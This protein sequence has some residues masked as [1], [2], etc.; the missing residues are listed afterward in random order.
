MLSTADYSVE[1]RRRCRELTRAGAWPVS[2]PLVVT[3]TEGSLDAGTLAQVQLRLTADGLR[4]ADARFR[5]F[6]CSAALASASF[7]ADALVGASLSETRGMDAGH[8]AH[9]LELPDDKRPMATLAVTAA[10]RA[11][12]AWERKCVERGT[13]NGEQERGR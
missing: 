7:V 10:K 1:V 4:V 13:G 9:E 8:I 2:D 11:I 12:A 6:G 5:V 3:G